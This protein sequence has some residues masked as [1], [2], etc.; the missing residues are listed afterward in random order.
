MIEVAN[1]VNEILPGL[2]LGAVPRQIDGYKYVLCVGERPTYHVQIGQ[3]AVCRPFNDSPL[4]PADEVLH[5]LADMTLAFAAKGRTLVHCTQG[6]NRSPLVVGL[7]LIKKGMTA[8]QALQHLR[9]THNSAVLSNK[10]F[11]QWLLNQK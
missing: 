8:E 4:V 1:P 7:A 5:E 2:W 10:A 3:M 11:E 9:T 6:I